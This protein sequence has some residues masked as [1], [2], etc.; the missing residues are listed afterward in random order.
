VEDLPVYPE[1]DHEDGSQPAVEPMEPVEPVES[2]LH[3]THRLVSS[4]SPVVLHYSQVF[5][6]FYSSEI[7]FGT[8]HCGTTAT[9]CTVYMK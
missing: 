2:T 9:Y 7:K 6:S 1:R 8:T 5:I 4:P 3:S